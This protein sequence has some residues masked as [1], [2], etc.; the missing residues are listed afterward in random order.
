MQTDA[1]VRA[2]LNRLRAE[3]ES[4]RDG[5]EFRS[6]D[7]NLDALRE[8]GRKRQESKLRE[9]CDSVYLD[10]EFR[11]HREDLGK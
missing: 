5:S 9:I 3:Y 11:S 6:Q 8:E 1:V 7:L 4:R 2:Q 10:D